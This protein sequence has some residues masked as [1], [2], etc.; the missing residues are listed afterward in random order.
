MAPS[1][2]AHQKKKPIGERALGLVCRYMEG[3]TALTMCFDEARSPMGFAD[4]RTVYAP[5]GLPSR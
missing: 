1:V 3:Y 4:I 2:A 5:T